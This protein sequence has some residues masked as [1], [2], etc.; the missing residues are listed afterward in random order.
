MKR[1]GL[2]SDVRVGG[3]PGHSVQGYC[4]VLQLK[5]RRAKAQL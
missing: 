2:M 5:I 4:D 3:H 1:E